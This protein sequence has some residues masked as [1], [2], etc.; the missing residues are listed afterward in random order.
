MAAVLYVIGFADEEDCVRRKSVC[1]LGD[2][3][4]EILVQPVLVVSTVSYFSTAASE[5]YGVI[6]RRSKVDAA[7]MNTSR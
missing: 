4:V 3:R 1:M 5:R 2:F 7:E 6:W